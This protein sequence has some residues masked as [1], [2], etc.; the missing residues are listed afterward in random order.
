MNALKSVLKKYAEPIKLGND[1]SGERTLEEFPS[2][3]KA[4][5]KTGNRFFS[6]CVIMLCVLFILSLALILVFL[7]DPA[8]ISVVFGITGVSFAW[9]VRM[10]F[11]IWKQKSYID[12]I[13]MIIGSTKKDISRSIITILAKK[14]K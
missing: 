1:D 2:D 8:K 3:L 13:M 6:V 11:K 12:I 5:R 7:N 10:M 14:L 4:V 9:I